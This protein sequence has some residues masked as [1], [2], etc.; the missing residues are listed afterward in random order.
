MAIKRC[1][2]NKYLTKF[3][4]NLLIFMWILCSSKKIIIC[5]KTEDAFLYPF[6]DPKPKRRRLQYDRANLQR[7]FDAT[8][9]G[10]S[11][12]RASREFCVPESTLRDRTRGNIT[13]NTKVGVGT[14]FTESEENLL[15]DHVKYMASIGY[16]YDKLVVQY[17]A[18][19]YAISLNR[20]VKS[21]DSLS[22]S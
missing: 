19:D 8:A 9:R 5:Y 21:K 22:S 20:S 18:R 1:D 3:K 2:R 10:M 17:M 6:Q 13:L 12:Y 15:V 16:G 7:A 14:L 4:K 11:V